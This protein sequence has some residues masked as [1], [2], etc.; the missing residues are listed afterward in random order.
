MSSSG[1]QNLLK[2]TSNSTLS[3][4]ILAK[5]IRKTAG[6]SDLST[7]VIGNVVVSSGK[8]AVSSA[9]KGKGT[10]SLCTMTPSRVFMDSDVEETRY[11]LSWL[12]SNEDVA[13]RVEAQVVTKTQPATLEGLLSYMKLADAKATK[14][15]TTLMCKKCGKS[16]IVGVPQYLSKISVYDHSEQAVFVLLGDAGQELT[17][18]KAS[19]LVESYY[20]A[21]ENVGADDLVH[22]LQALVDTIGQTRKFIVKVSTNNL[23]SKTQ[24]LTVTKVLPLE[25][26]E[27]E[28][29]LGENVANGGDDGMEDT[30]AEMVKRSSDG[31]E[32]VGV[33]RA[34]CG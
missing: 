26:A 32:L 5:R 7:D 24:V 8:V 11:Y 19:E 15:A 6:Y 12:N 21:N 4:S 10:L 20:E 28:G 23:T 27:L 2:A 17:G 16:D 31:I 34:K 1:D 3:S 13:N 18:K 33:K 14:W 25:V 30:A 22:V 29:G 9:D